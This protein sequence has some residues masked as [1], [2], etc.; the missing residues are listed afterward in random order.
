ML[1]VSKLMVKSDLPILYLDPMFTDDHT[2]SI[3]FT[4][5]QK[6]SLLVCD[7]LVVVTN[8]WDQRK[9]SVFFVGS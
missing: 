9:S 4:T 7:F 1:C 5:E 3:H 2:H 6:P 8:S